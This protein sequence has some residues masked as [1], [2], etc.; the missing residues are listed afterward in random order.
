MDYDEIQTPT[1]LTDELWQRS[2]HCDHYREH[3]YFTDDRR[4]G[5]SRSS[6]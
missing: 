6:R 1:M 4:Q 3:M 5:R 2:G